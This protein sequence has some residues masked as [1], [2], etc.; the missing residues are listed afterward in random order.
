MRR[1]ARVSRLVL[2]APAAGVLAVFLLLPYLNIIIMSFRPTV[3]GAVY[4]P[5]YTVA[6]Y[7]RFFTDS[8]ELG[9]FLD[10]FWIAAVPTVL[11]AVLGYPVAWQLARGKTRFRALYYGIVLSPLLVGIVI[12]SYGWTIILGNNGLINRTLHDW[13]IID[14]RL[15]LMYNSLGIIIALTH[16][17]LPFMILPVMGAIQGID[18]TLESAARSLGASRPKIFL[19]IILPLSM[20]GIQAGSILVFVLALS[21]YVTPLLIGGMRVKTFA[22]EVVETLVDRFQWP[23]GAA[24][25]LILA[26][27]GALV[28]VVFAR[29]TR[30]KWV[31][32]A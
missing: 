12:R 10:T 2:L 20:P 13:G 11:C 24:Y 32:A 9:Q 3:T 17:F 26:L 6:N 31:H 1:R 14:G 19:R 21:A 5:G 23:L 25:A 4:G 29:L 22:V 7:T 18:P 30:M 27:G 28:V 8:Y 15:P 16:V